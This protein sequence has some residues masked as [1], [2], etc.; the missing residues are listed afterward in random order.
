MIDKERW[1]EEILEKLKHKF[2]TRLLFVGLQG[3][4]RRGEATEASDF[5]MVTV[6][7]K[8]SVGDLAFYRSLLETMPEHEKACGFICGRSELQ[9]WPRHELFQFARDTDSY[10]GTMDGLLP[11]WNEADLRESIRISAANLYHA[12]CHLVLYEDK[13]SWAEGLEALYKAV[14]FP[15]Q[16]AEYLR[17][18]VY[19]SSKTALLPH[20]KGWEAALLEKSIKKEINQKDLQENPEAFFTPLIEWCQ[21]TLAQYRRT[22]Q[23]KK[24]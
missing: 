2:G 4:Y 11:D 16:L 23:Q 6:L 24:D 15:L 7:D 21:S 20:L 5:D 8:L 12:A 17:G 14:F 10:Y 22:T 18:G 1:M 3:S 19:Y 13:A 9:N